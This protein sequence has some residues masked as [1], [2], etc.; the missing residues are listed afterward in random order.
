LYL[1]ATQLMH[2]SDACAVSLLYL[3]K[4]QSVHPAAEAVL[5]LNFPA[6]HALTND[7]TEPV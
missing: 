3:P 5:S 2:V 1:P 4:A 7:K 6:A